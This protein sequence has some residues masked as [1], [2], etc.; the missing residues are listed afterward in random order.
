ML[1]DGRTLRTVGDAR[2]FILSLPPREQLRSQWQSLANLL[3]SAS[4]SANPTL[5]AIVSDRLRDAVAST[6]LGI[7][8]KKPAAPSVRR[9]QSVIGTKGRGARQ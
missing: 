3:L 4:Y 8:E 9:G 2:R 5:I 1:G 7:V 6:Q